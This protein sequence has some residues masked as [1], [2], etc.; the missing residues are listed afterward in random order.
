MT[1]KD[2]LRYIRTGKLGGV[3]RII[4]VDGRGNVVLTKRVRK[5]KSSTKSLLNFD[6]MGGV[7]YNT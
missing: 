5:R 2:S 1:K 6:L 3:E 7:K 4:G